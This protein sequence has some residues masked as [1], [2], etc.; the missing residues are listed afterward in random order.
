[1]WDR[2][3]VLVLLSVLATLPILVGLAS[4]YLLEPVTHRGKTFWEVAG[5]TVW[6]EAVVVAVL[7]LL[8]QMVP[9]FRELLELPNLGPGM[10][11]REEE[12]ARKSSRFAVHASSFLL[13]FGGLWLMAATAL[14]KHYTL[15]PSSLISMALAIQFL[16]YGAAVYYNRKM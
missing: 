12:I 6:T 16:F 13:L 1:M 3:F 8:A 15:Q 5:V 11:E 7:F 10:D 2:T 14:H 4:T 9:R